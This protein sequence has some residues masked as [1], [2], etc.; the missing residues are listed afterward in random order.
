VAGGDGS[1]HGEVVEGII[2]GPTPHI[3]AHRPPGGGRCPS[4]NGGQAK[5]SGRVD[6]GGER[7]EGHSG[8]LDG[9]PARNGPARHHK[10]KVSQGIYHSR[11][12]LVY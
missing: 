6:D 5:R 10:A 8:S 4:K 1:G 3:D 7:G 11:T 12:C 2:E 9:S